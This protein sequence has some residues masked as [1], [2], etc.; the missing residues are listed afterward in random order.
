M[1][2]QSTLENLEVMSDGDSITTDALERSVGGSPLYHLLS[3]EEKPQYLLQGRILDL[4]DRDKS[5]S[6]PDRKSRKVADPDSAL[7]T[8]LTDERVLIV[9]PRRN[10]IEQVNIPYTEVSQVDIETAP[11]S[12]R[13]RVFTDPTAYHIDV[14]QSDSDE[15]QAAQSYADEIEL[16][17]STEKG[18]THSD[19]GEILDTV[20][21]LSNLY[22][23]GVLSQTEFEEKKTDLLDRL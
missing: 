4:V 12:Q 3:D 2:D 1:V 10:E 11:G 18:A 19:T 17:T 20:E 9:V 6:D 23:K 15:A 7:K 21:R 14:S 16:P 8:I 13:L 22:D 5:E